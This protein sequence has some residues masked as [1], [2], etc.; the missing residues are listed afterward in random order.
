MEYTLHTRSYNG[1]RMQPI[2]RFLCSECL[3][4]F[5]PGLVL[6]T[7]NLRIVVDV[8]DQLNS[9]FNEKRPHRTHRADDE[10]T[11]HITVTNGFLCA[12]M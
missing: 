10:I 11:S 1:S 7:E 4:I 3:S 8:E 5:I 6:K 12:N 9:Q 2:V